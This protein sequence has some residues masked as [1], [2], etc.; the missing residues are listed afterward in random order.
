MLTSIAALRYDGQTAPCLLDAPI[1][2]TLEAV[3]AVV[4]ALLK[5]LTPIHAATSMLVDV[6]L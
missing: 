3:E 2:P 6:L 5:T 4:A 1:R